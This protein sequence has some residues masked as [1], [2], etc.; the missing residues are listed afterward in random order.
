MA[1]EMFKCKT[2]F[3]AKLFQAIGLQICDKPIYNRQVHYTQG[4]FCFL[5]LARS[6]LSYAQPITGQV[7]EVTC[8]VID[9]AQA[10]LTPSKRQK[11]GPGG[12]LNIKMSYQY[13][14]PH[15]QDKTVS[16]PSYL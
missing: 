14:D 10:E 3:I 6:K 2:I 4:P 12:R 16:R 11:T 13:R 1:F 5:S 8:P 15:V 7:T 9:R